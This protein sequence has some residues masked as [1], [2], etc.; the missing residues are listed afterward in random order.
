MSI[1]IRGGKALR[2]RVRCDGAKNAALPIMAGSILTDDAVEI[3]NV[4]F[5]LDVETMVLVLRAIG[6][7]AV[8][9]GR[10]VKI[11]S[12][13]S[14]QTEAPYDLVRRMRASFLVMGPL[15][16][17]C[18]TA[19]VPL[20]GGCAIGQ[21]PVD[22]HLKGFHAMGA[23]ISVEHG[24]VT[25]KAK[26]LKGADIYLDMPSVGA[27]ENIMMA[28]SL[29]DGESIIENAAQEPEIVDLANFLNAMGADI[30]G[31]GTTRIRIS[32]VKKLHGVQYN[33][34][35]DRIEAATY[36]IAVAM[37]KGK[38]TIENVI[39]THLRSVLAKIKECGAYLF[40]GPRS[41]DIEMVQAPRSTNIKTQPYPGF[42][43]D[44]QAPYMALCAISSGTSIISE[45]V[46]D[47]R[48]AHA[49]ELG[50]MGAK[51]RI[52]GPNAIIEGVPRLASAEV[53]ATDLRAGA[54]LTL[55]GLAAVGE[56][57]VTGTEHIERGYSD[58][59]HKLRRLGADVENVPP[60]RHAGLAQR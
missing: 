43:T 11:S 17:R 22:L 31:A 12:G 3:G 56:T 34:I 58:F 24:F 7:N 1:L 47:N 46:F 35:P 21:R 28:A 5:L 42:P 15:L 10:S 57:E 33:I 32:G 6:V 51:I 38:V 19:S 2:G 53:R 27:T 40:E 41:I 59:V 54:A 45:T 39:P 16:V 8:Y 49:E 30:R 44:V 20:P 55:A 18:K 50:R 25:A 23:D 60:K 26:H 37:S 13:R 9:S 4:P 52:E 36:A 14:L 29:A 48:F